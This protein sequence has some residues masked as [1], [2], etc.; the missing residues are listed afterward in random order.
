MFALDF[1]S[2]ILQAKVRIFSLDQG[3]NGKQEKKGLGVGH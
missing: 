3:L 1:Y 2:F